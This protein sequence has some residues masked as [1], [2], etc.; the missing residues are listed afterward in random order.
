MSTA[1]EIENSWRPETESDRHLVLAQL[2]ELLSGPY[3]RNSKRYPGLLRFVVERTLDGHQESLKERSIGIEVFHRTPDYDTNEDP[4]VRLSAAEVRKR[5]TR[6]YQEP[7]HHNELKIELNPGSYIPVFYRPAS[8]AEHSAGVPSE[9]SSP[10][11][12]GI[13][14]KTRRRTWIAY[15]VIGALVLVLAV[16]PGAY[17]FGKPSIL[18]QFW[19]P[20]ITSPRLVT[21]CVGEPH[22]IDDPPST[23][24]A[25]TSTILNALRHSARL[26]SSDVIALIHVGAALE[27]RRKEF[28]FVPTTQVRF[29]QLA[30]GPVILVG[31]FD[32]SWTM[33]LTQSLRFGFVQSDDIVGIVDHRHPGASNW[34]IHL[35]EAT[36]LQSG[37][38]A[39]VARYHDATLDQPVVIVA[40][41][42]TQGT[43]AAGK[44]LSNPTFLKAIFQQVKGNWRTVNVEAVV[45]TQVIDGS[46]G[47]PRVLA[48]ESW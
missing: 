5:L 44:M 40:G 16:V 7:A 9:A 27:N 38:F 15:G 21:I 45:Q 3:F 37:D 33:R 1:E 48:V 14:S 34:S 30:E 11:D 4:V 35:K 13:P 39:L 26:A 6:Y 12:P 22:S 8:D 28:R 10:V 23:G 25:A 24:G 20:T 19:A 41:L 18:D 31:A 47:P 43:E 29:S 17:Y 2:E 36:N 42:S 32:N 46:P